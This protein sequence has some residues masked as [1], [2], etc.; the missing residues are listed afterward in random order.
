MHQHFANG[1][2]ERVT[3]LCPG[4]CSRAQPAKDTVTPVCS[5]LIFQE[6]FEEGCEE[7]GRL[8]RSPEAC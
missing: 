7:P 5:C 4:K 8:P 6:F 3:E 2:G 1:V